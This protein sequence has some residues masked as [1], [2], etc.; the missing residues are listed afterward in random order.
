MFNTIIS[1]QKEKRYIIQG[2]IVFLVFLAM[3]FVL[4]SLNIGYKEMFNTY[5]VYPKISRMLPLQFEKSKS[6][7]GWIDDFFS[8]LNKE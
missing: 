3:Y 6:S 4:D 8:Q 2:L 5:G 7:G 1:M